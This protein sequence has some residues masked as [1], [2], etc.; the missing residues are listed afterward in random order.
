MHSFP[1][2]KGLLLGLLC[3]TYVVFKMS[4]LSIS[5]LDFCRKD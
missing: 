2:F 3:G 4:M 5:L 1:F